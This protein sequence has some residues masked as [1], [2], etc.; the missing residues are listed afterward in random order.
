LLPNRFSTGDR[1]TPAA[2][3]IV[4]TAAQGLFFHAAKSARRG[5]AVTAAAYNRG[6][7]PRVP[8]LRRMGLLAATFTARRDAPTAG[9]DGHDEHDEHDAI[10]LLAPAAA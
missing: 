5:N 6:A 9:Q 2:G 8:A 7:Q 4:R 1:Q 3:A 10:W